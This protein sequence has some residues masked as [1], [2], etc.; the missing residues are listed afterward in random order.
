[1]LKET[2]I[3][4]KSPLSDWQKIEAINIF[5]ISKAQ[6]HPRASTPYR[7]WAQSIDKQI[8]KILKPSLKLPKR[9]ATSF[10]YSANKHGGVGLRSLE[11]DLDTARVTHFFKCL[12]SPD[13]VV[14]QCAWSQLSQV[15]IRRTNNKTPTAEDIA[16]FLNTPPP[17]KES[18]RCSDVQSI[19]SIVRKS[20][21]RL[22]MT[23]NISPDFQI[24]LTHP[25][26]AIDP[27]KRKV[28]SKVIR[29][30]AQAQQLK[31]LI[32]APD[33]GRAFP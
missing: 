2:E 4:A 11:D 14:T 10:L 12:T 16:S 24:Q 15:V 8:R 7:T 25:E 31:N 1:M 32:E 33:Q 17:P 27:T 6:Y 13:Q 30:E 19:W 28:I 23:V 21:H 22:N 9:T 20:L 29:M 5:V 18:T 26:G 3:I